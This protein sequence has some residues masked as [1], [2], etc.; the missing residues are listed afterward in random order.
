MLGVFHCFSGLLGQRVDFFSYCRG[1]PRAGAGFAQAASEFH[2]DAA[3]KTADFQ[4][5]QQAQ[6]PAEKFHR[7]IS[8]CIFAIGNP[9]EMPGAR[10]L[11]RAFQNAVSLR[12][13]HNPRHASIEKPAAKNQGLPRAWARRA[14]SLPCCA[15]ALKAAPPAAAGKNAGAWKTGAA[16]CS[17]PSFFDSCQRKLH[18]RQR[19]I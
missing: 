5:S 19:P 15:R 8:A 10:V 7:I 9:L 4:Q 2:S 6:N 17:H 11:V 14:R 12:A 3:G 18:K 16:L 1:R 13:G